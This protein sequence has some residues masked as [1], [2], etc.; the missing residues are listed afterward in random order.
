M[1]KLY[2]ARL[3]ILYILNLEA[4]ESLPSSVPEMNELQL[5]MEENGRVEMN[6]YIRENV[7]DN[8]NIVQVIMFGRADEIIIKFAEKKKADLIIM[9]E[10]RLLSNS[11]SSMPDTIEKV[12][13]GTNIPV[14]KINSPVRDTE[15]Q[16]QSLAD[17]KYWL[18][19]FGRSLFN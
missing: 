5:S 11:I 16:F 18:N 13:T 3:Y 1:S 8:L 9:E 14:L 17:K 2:N 15:L 6:R 12:L 10:T 7:K 4:Y 19:T